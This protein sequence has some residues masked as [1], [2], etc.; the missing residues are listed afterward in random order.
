VVTG[1]RNLTIRLNRG[2]LMKALMI[3]IDNALVAMREASTA[4]PHIEIQIMEEKEYQGLLIADNGPGIPQP[5]ETLVFEPYFSFQKTGRGL[6]LHIARDILAM[7]NSSISQVTG[8]S[9]LSG[10]CFEI[11]FDRRRVVAIYSDMDDQ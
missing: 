5:F 2:H 10:A 3:V 9:R 4:D 8:R 11:R 1:S 7:F 6:G